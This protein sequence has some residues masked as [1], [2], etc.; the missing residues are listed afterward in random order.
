MRWFFFV[1]DA[2]DKLI[3][4]CQDKRVSV[5]DKLRLVMVYCIAQGGIADATRRELMQSVDAE[6]Q[7]AIRN[8]DKLG[9][10]LSNKGS[11]KK[12][13]SKERTEE[14][15]ARAEAQQ[16][17]LMRYLPQLHSVIEQL[18]TGQL[19]ED[20]FPYTKPPPPGSAPAAAS[21]ASAAGGA[22]GG[23]SARKGVS[24]RKA[25][26]NGAADWK[27]GESGSA[28]AASSSGAAAA[29]ASPSAA[30]EEDNRPR[31]IVFVLGGLT[32]SEMRSCY[33]LADKHHAHLL[34]GSTNTSTPASFIKDLANLTDAQ[35]DAAI[36]ASLAA[37]GG[38]AGGSG[39]GRNGAASVAAAGGRGGARRNP[40]NE[41]SDDDDEGPI[42]PRHLHVQI[43]K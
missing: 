42:G 36:A 1:Q 12:K 35:F 29:S 43:K 17:N 23:A 10:D 15:R 3:S 34:L 9:V 2:K 40:A 37:A 38:P 6:L 20:A 18:I 11:E 30:S 19:K 39:G 22:A 7:A 5:L 21:G 27:S 32:Y 16:L 14:L 4:L 8:L 25:R 33:E 31:F 41:D 13:L 24:A 26:Q 28:A